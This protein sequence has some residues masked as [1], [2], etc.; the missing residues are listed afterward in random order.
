M[1]LSGALAIAS[2]GLANINLQLATVSQNVANAN[3]SGYSSEVLP[4]QSMD[5]AGLAMGVRTG[6]ATRLTDA[7]AQNTLYAEN[8]TVASLTLRQTALQGIDAVQGAP[9]S[10][11]D[12]ASLLGTLQ[13]GF[14]ALLANPANAAAQQLVVQQ[15]G[16]L[17]QGINQLSGTYQSARQNAEQTVV[18]DLATLNTALGQ[19]GQL[20]LQIVA[21]KSLGTSTAG[22]EDQ[23]AAAMQQVSGLVSAKFVTLA[24]G[25]LQVF[26]P[27]GLTLPIHG[28][29]NPLSTIPVN[30]APGNAYPG[31]GIPGIMLAGVDV[32]SQLQG[33]EIGQAITLRDQTLPSYQAG[34]DEFSQNLASRFQAQGLTLFS[35]PAGN[36]PAPGAPVQQNYV[37]FAGVI[38]VNPQVAANPALVR[39]GT[40]TGGAALNPSGLAGFTGLIG[41]VVDYAL[42]ADSAPGVPQPP[43]NTS[44]LGPSGTIS[45]GFAAPPTLAGF[46]SA[47]LGAEATDSATT[48]S[49]L[50]AA[51]ATQTSYQSQVSSATGVNVDQ[52]LSLMVALQN[53]Y[54]ANAKVIGAV[55]SMWTQLL[56]IVP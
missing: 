24:N 1:G 8:A 41:N 10:G 14:S 19:I 12:I 27:S 32:T 34:L 33:G 30:T 45:L 50:S 44:G 51:Q 2:S 36:V 20:S 31:A 52:Q 6:V 5:A 25:D 48:T 35:D 43:S 54:A 28:T 55:Q 23:R 16:T 3:S 7:A 26:T 53:S 49:S 18:S 13:N 46:A 17:A 15:A 21:G 40:L 9:G 29:T 56:S 4:Q 37:G 39:D 47:L 42:G 38:G 22:L 11:S